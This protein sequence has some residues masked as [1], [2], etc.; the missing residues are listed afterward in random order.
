ME[1]G[2]NPLSP[3][4]L[5]RDELVD[6]HR[7]TEDTVEASLRAAGPF[8]CIANGCQGAGGRHR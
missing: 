4:K 6:L 2:L 3:R 8:S 5:N 1:S 7:P